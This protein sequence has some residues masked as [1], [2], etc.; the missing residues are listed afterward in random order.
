MLCFSH[1]DMQ[2]TARNPWWEWL[3]IMMWVARD[4]LPLPLS[5]ITFTLRGKNNRKK[6]RNRMPQFWH[7]QLLPLILTNSLIA[8]EI[9]VVMESKICEKMSPSFWHSPTIHQDSENWRW[10]TTG[11]KIYTQKS[12][13]FPVHQRWTH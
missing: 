1:T 8:F 12:K 5:Q 13:A 3:M 2:T 9:K 7:K 11:Y 10:R 6:E 4:Q